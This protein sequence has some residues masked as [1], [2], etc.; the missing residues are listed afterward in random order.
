MAI[1]IEFVPIADGR[2]RGSISNSQRPQFIEIANLDQ[3]TS[4]DIFKSS[5]GSIDDG[6][7]PIWDGRTI[8]K[9]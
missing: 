4:S 3:T 9:T 6:C 2:C 7:F 5:D 1:D 8:H